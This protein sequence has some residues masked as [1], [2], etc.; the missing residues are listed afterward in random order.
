M[1]SVV[2]IKSEA[3][4]IKKSPARAT[5]S[6]RTAYKKI[7]L[8]LSGEALQGENLSIDPKV[9]HSISQQV[10]DIQSLGIQVAIVIGG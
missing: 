7:L 6:D 3:K 4:G 8:K 9:V 5:L 2:R 1:S 10:Q